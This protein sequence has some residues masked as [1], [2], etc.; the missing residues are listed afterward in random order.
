MADVTLSAATRTEFGKGAARRLRR[1][2]KTPA[3]LYGHGTDPVH[4]ALPRRRPSS[5]SAPPTPCSR[6]PSTAG[7]RPSSRSPSRSPATRSP[8]SSST[9]T[10]CW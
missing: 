9:S 7:R 10:S 3:V 8:R 6:S 4:L 2:G 5:R 1:S